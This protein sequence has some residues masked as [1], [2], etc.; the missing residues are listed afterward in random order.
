MYIITAEQNSV[1]FSLKDSTSGRKQKVLAVFQRSCN[2]T[3]IHKKPWWTR[4]MG[5]KSQRQVWN[6]HV[7]SSGS[8][9]CSPQDIGEEKIRP[10]ESTSSPSTTNVDNTPHPHPPPLALTTC[11]LLE[12]HGVRIGARYLGVNTNSV[13]ALANEVTLAGPHFDSW[14]VFRPEAVRGRRQLK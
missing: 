4:P 7:R 8:E 2:F 10:C 6:S 11:R 1:L 5:Y 12:K 9:I 14:Q 3:V 13:L